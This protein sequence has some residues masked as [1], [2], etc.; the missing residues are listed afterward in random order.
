MSLL[1]PCN[2]DVLQYL[3]ILPFRVLLSQISGKDAQTLT[4][5]PSACVATHVPSIVSSAIL[6]TILAFALAF[7]LASV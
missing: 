4:S 1:W 3:C 6:A 5:G 2:S 7:A